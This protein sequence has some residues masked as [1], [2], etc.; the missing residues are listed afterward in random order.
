MTAQ[1]RFVRNTDSTDRRSFSHC[2]LIRDHDGPHRIHSGQTMDPQSSWWKHVDYE[3][4]Y[5]ALKDRVIAA[6]MI[7][8]IEDLTI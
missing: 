6:G 4:E 1:C 5:D 2:S 7:E 8:L 3:R